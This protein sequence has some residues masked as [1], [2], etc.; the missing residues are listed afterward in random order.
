MR[1]FCCEL[2]TLGNIINI[3]IGRMNDSLRILSTICERYILLINKQCLTNYNLNIAFWNG[4]RISDYGN[5]KQ[6]IFF[7]Y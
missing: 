6:F 2:A 5:K 3:I 1:Y 7:E 4:Y